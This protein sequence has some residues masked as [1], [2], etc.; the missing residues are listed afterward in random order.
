MQPHGCNACR[1][2]ARWPAAAWHQVRVGGRRCAMLQECPASKLHVPSQPP[3]WG[4]LSLAEP[5]FQQRQ[6]AA[7]ATSPL[8]SM[9]Y[10]PTCD[11]CGK[12]AVGL[13]RCSR[14]RAA[15]YCS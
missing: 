3:I 6:L 5:S 11:G 9:F 12:P 1:R 13:R 10:H 7:M 4:P 15:S 2:Q 8:D 14:C